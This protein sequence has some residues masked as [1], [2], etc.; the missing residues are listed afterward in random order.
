M[1][2]GVC[3]PGLCSAASELGCITVSS[4]SPGSIVTAVVHPMA[5]LPQIPSPDDTSPSTS[6]DLVDAVQT[7]SQVTDGTA[8]HMVIACLYA[9][10]LFEYLEN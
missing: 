5:P 8:E 9:S 4:A 7:P 6:P 10:L 2:G 1:C 3:R